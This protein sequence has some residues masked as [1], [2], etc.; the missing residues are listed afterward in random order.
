MQ[1]VQSIDGQQAANHQ[2]YDESHVVAD[3]VESDYGHIGADIDNGAMQ[4]DNIEQPSV[5]SCQP[6]S[7]N[8]SIDKNM[9]LR[10]QA[11]EQE[12]CSLKNNLN[13][14]NSK[15][16]HE[17]GGPVENSNAITNSIVSSAKANVEALT[18]ELVKELSNFG[19]I[20]PLL[21]DDTVNDILIN[22]HSQIYVERI[23]KLQGTNITFE[24]ENS[25]IDIANKIVTL[26]GRKVNGNRPLIDTRLQDG[27]RVNIIAPP[28]AV[29]GTVISIRKFS[30]KLL[31]LDVMAS[32][33]NMS[34]SLAE[35]LKVVGKSRLNILISGGT[36]SGKTTMLNAMSQHIS[37]DERIVTIEDVAEIKMQQPHVV[38][39]ESRTASFSDVP[40]DE[41]T[42]RDLVK[43]SLRMR[44]DRI[45]VGECRGVEA[46]DMMQ[47]MNTGHEGS[48]TTVHANH[49]RDA[50]AR[51]ENMI[52]MADLGLPTQAIRS[53]IA[54]AINVIVHVSRMRDGHRRIQ[55]VSEITGMEKDTIV[56]QELFKF[57]ALGE[58]ADGKLVGRFEW[59]GIMPRFIR[60]A[61][62]YG[63]KERLSHALGVKL[64]NFQ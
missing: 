46:F 9:E 14:A 20:M 33:G 2:Q 21:A 12:I 32:Q 40:E 31:T 59:T 27:S 3:M 37:E 11:L 50:L 8:N 53:Q 6:E 63:E 48:I 38:R 39:L 24:D 13:N 30:K 4:Q 17:A 44:P 55:S 61:A 36:G 42:I 54:S 35:L 52:G 19:P 28:L 5:D 22:G 56:M 62:Y 7:E 29:D 57:N 16:S 47:A 43:N 41:V 26:A 18:D 25:V 10:L 49:P 58:D 1:Q 60:R 51:L 64:P 15:L 34:G 23:G 45:I